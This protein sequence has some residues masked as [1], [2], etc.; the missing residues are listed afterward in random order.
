MLK[1]HPYTSG[2]KYY[3]IT[4]SNNEVYF[5]AAGMS[6]FTMHKVERRRQRCINRHKN[7]KTNGQNQIWHR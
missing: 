7:N 6:D 2:K 3:I 5:G 4:E 1:Y